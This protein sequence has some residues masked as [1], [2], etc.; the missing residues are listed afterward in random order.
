MGRCVRSSQKPPG[1]RGADRAG[2]SFVSRCRNFGSRGPLPPAR[3][4]PPERSVISKHHFKRHTRVDAGGGVTNT[5]SSASA[6]KGGAVPPCIQHRA[7][8]AQ[9]SGGSPSFGAESGAM[10]RCA[11]FNACGADHEPARREMLKKV[12]TVREAEGKDATAR[13]AVIG[14]SHPHE[15]EGERR[16]ER[17]R[18]FAPCGRLGCPCLLAGDCWRD[19]P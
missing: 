15:S 3:L 16:K 4:T 13:F 14:V 2:K 6:A 11:D 12:T 10:P 7:D 17:G 1:A 18:R 9:G 19:P 5:T 8:G